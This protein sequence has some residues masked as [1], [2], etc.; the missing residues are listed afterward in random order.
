LGAPRI[1]RDRTPLA[2]DTRKAI[3]LLAYLALADPGALYSRDSL[4]ALFWPE[5]DPPRAHGALRRTL[6]ALNKALDGPWLRI[7]RDTLGFERDADV[8]IDVDAFHARL[9]ESRTHGHSPGEVCSAC[10]PLLEQAVAEYRGDFMAGFSLRDSPAFDDWQFFQAEALRRLLAGALERLVAGYSAQG[11]PEALETALGHARH[12]LALDALHEPAHR[13]VMLLYAWTSQRAAALRQYRECVRILDQELGVGPLDETTRLYEAIR[14]NRPPPPPLALAAPAPAPAAAAPAPPATVSLPL[15]GRAAEWAALQADYNAAAPD[16][17]LVVLE[18]EAG[19]G[20]TRLAETL[21]HHVRA[22]GGQAL[23]AR[24]YQGEASLAYGPF[25]EAVRAAIVPGAQPPGW[26]A[27]LAPHFAADAGRLLPE[28]LALAPH[29]PPMPVLDQA[30][31]QT[32]F[33]ESLRQVV[34]AALAGNTPGLL[35]IDD[36]HWMD[37]ASLD[38][39]SYLVRRWRGQSLC[40]VLTW[41][42]E[43]VPLGHRLRQVLA[44]AQRAGIGRLLRLERLDRAAVAE[45]VRQAWPRDSAQVAQASA[46]DSALV[47]RLYRESEGLPYFV[48]EYLNSLSAEPASAEANWA[49]P[50]GVRNL[51]QAR[52]AR[53][54][55]TGW[56]LL[57]TAAVIGRS[58]DFDSL[59][60]ASGRSDEEAVAAL[61]VLTSA[62]LINEVESAGPGAGPAYDFSHDKLRVLVYAEISL[63][64]RRLLHRRVAEGLADRARRGPL[65]GGAAHLGAAASQIAYHYQQAGRDAD[66]AEYFLLAGEHAR[67]LYANAE[68]LAHFRS[69]LALGHPAAAGLHEAIGDLLTLGGL[70]DGALTSFERAAALSASS[71]LARLEHKLGS[72]YHRQGDWELAESHFQAA[73]NALGSDLRAEARARL[74]ADWSLAA[75]Q[76]GDAHRAQQLAQQS[77]NLA[78]AAGD[79][80]ALAQVHNILGILATSQAQPEQARRHLERSLA[81]AEAWGDPGPRAAALNNLAL[82]YGHLGQYASAVRL[83][84]QALSLC[85]AQGDRH[86]EA[87]LHNNLADLLY[88]SGQA[89]AAEE[90]VKRSVMIYAEIGTAAGAGPLQPEIWKLAEW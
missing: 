5:V 24:C 6:S 59:H 75:H 46:P 18:G 14:E 7:E 51:L 13:Q 73:L 12:W 71:D 29:A 83:A 69:A 22:H 70:Y 35:M 62:G 65:A 61:E 76:R 88:A 58:F 86:R 9:T 36:V 4:A 85:R 40:L 56:Q 67:A 32:R 79:R 23:V 43:E 31:A 60:A 42:G 72:V 64:R 52:L 82:A 84:E 47:E 10:L 17:R 38:L 87:A 80:P 89:A 90:H 54:D 11:L 1:E 81:L 74:F 16:G 48:V 28:L 66:A 15:V 34:L 30:G 21:L 8:Y 19:I 2:V 25:V 41:R 26:A 37:E 44:E 53:V 55:E 68:A 49:L 63:A 20:K 78:E 39:L 77:L 57:T 33:Y 50:G 3:A 45:L 27:R